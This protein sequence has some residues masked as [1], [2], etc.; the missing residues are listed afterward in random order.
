MRVRS[1]VLV[2]RNLRLMFIIQLAAE[3]IMKMDRMRKVKSYR[4]MCLGRYIYSHTR[5]K[6]FFF[7]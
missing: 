7:N 4:D 3:R 1:S 6:V 5:L 2:L